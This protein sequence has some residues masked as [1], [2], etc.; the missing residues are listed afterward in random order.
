MES[1]FF[2]FFLQ[3]AGRFL[4]PALLSEI[5]RARI[6]RAQE[7]QYPAP[8]APELIIRWLRSVLP[9]PE[10]APAPAPAPPVA[11][12]LELQVLRPI[13]SPVAYL[14]ISKKCHYSRLRE[15][16]FRKRRSRFRKKWHFFPAGS[17]RLQKLHEYAVPCIFMQFCPSCHPCSRCKCGASSGAGKKCS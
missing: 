16:F 15:R 7:R 9:A 14:V 1:C 8:L 5:F 13:P 10:P 17:C 12:E 2:L 3:W 4:F 11:P 6:M